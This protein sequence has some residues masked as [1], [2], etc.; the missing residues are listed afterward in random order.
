MKI[1]GYQETTITTLWLK[2]K[3]LT[4]NILHIL[5]EKNGINRDSLIISRKISNIV[6][7]V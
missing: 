7:T 6:S 5:Y 4:D 2:K 1:C 3:K